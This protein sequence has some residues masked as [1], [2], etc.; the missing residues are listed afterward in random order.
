MKRKIVITG[1]KVHDVGYR[2][3]L[4]NAALDLGFE[5]FN[6][7]NEMRNGDQAVVSS[8]DGDDDQINQFMYFAEKNKPP[9]AQVTSVKSEDY[10]GRVM[11]IDRYLHVIQ[12]QQLDKGIKTMQSMDGKLDSVNVKL[13]SMN[14]KTDLMLGKQDETI[15]EIKALREDLIER[16]NVRFARIERDIAAIKAKL[17]MS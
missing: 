7:T 16:D 14:N 10:T 6:I 13:D 5:L 3:F 12:V 1:T 2:V 11:G 17:E 9:L 4:L 8:L 15:N